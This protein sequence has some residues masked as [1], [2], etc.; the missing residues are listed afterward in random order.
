MAD[1]GKLAGLFG[2]FL[3]G[4]HRLEPCC[5]CSLEVAVDRLCSGDAPVARDVDLGE[6]WPAAALVSS[7]R[8]RTLFPEAPGLG[9]S[10]SPTPVAVV[11]M[12]SATRGAASEHRPLA[13]CVARLAAAGFAPE[14]AA[15]FYVDSDYVRH[16][17][18]E[19]RALFRCHDPATLAKD[20]AFIRAF[21]A[22]SGVGVAPAGPVEPYYRA[23]LDALP[24]PADAGALR[25]WAWPTPAPEV[26]DACPRPESPTRYAVAD[27]G[28]LSAFFGSLRYPIRCLDFETFALTVPPYDGTRPNATVPFQYS[29]HRLDAPDA[30]PA[31]AEFLHAGADN[32]IP[33][34]LEQL[35]G[36][37]GETGT[38]LIWT[39]YE[40]QVLDQAVRSLAYANREAPEDSK[41]GRWLQSLGMRW[42]PKKQRFVPGVGRIVDLAHPFQA[43]WL[44][45]PDS[46][47][48]SIKHVYPLLVGKGYSDLAIQDGLDASDRFL[49]LYH[50]QRE[51]GDVVTARRDLLAYCQRDTEAMVETL[52]AMRRLS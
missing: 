34:L 22:A 15:L 39:D 7:D 16:G 30:A 5:G 45:H 25:Q 46:A 41:Y 40:C 2:E 24:V 12:T 17:P 38:I 47:R 23:E 51:V 32:P 26:A 13:V 4:G 21:V 31:H 44:R 10:G 43:G 11:R 18:V 42:A 27:R 6:G 48:Y 50:A 9:L 20:N 35:R 1:D 37:L 3:D 36:D 14:Y 33:P 8:F 19:P 29:L 52:A 49:G 28:P